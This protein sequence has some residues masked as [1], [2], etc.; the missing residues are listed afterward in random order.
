[1]NT[2][3]STNRVAHC[4]PNEPRVAKATP[5]NDNEPNSSVETRKAESLKV[6]VAVSRWLRVTVDS[7]GRT[8]ILASIAALTLL[9]LLYLYLH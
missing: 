8:I 2:K 9:G 5:A 7:T 6:T 3:H 1:M 4:R